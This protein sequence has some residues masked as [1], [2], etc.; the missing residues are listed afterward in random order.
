MKKRVNYD[1]YYQS[2]ALFGN[3]YEQLLAFYREFPLR[4]TLLDVGCGQGRDA[5]VLAGMGFEVRGIDHS[6]VGIEQM[7]AEAQRAKLSLKGEVLDIYQYQAFDEYDFIL[8]DSMFHFGKKERAKEIEFIV[9]IMRTMRAGAIISI[10]IA[11]TG[12]KYKILETTVAQEKS[13]QTIQNDA[14]N[15]QYIDQE[16][17]HTSITPYKMLSLKKAGV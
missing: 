4:G 7:L 14:F 3:P 16:S 10:C 17:S 15:Y 2:P 9:R 5:L 6:T 13:F 1:D 12:D 8:L 11:N